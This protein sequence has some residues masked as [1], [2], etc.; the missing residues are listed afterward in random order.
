MKRTPMLG[1]TGKEDH[2]SL[3]VAPIRRYTLFLSAH[4]TLQKLENS[5]GCQLLFD[6]DS[7]FG[8]FLCDPLFLLLDRKTDGH[9]FFFFCVLFS[10]QRNALSPVHGILG[11]DTTM[12]TTSCRVMVVRSIGMVMR[13]AA[14]C[15]QN[16]QR[17]PHVN[18]L[19]THS[20][21]VVVD[22]LVCCCCHHRATGM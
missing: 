15:R 11:R 14:A 20:L 18:S 12:A 8:S 1:P 9:G 5:H 6:S 4:N 16:F 10:P 3:I 22:D 7:S 21:F 13:M 17:F 2:N 19:R